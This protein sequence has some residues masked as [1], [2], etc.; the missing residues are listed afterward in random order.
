[1]K[2]LK[3]IHKSILINLLYVQTVHNNMYT[4]N[5]IYITIYCVIICCGIHASLQPADKETRVKVYNI[6]YYNTTVISHMSIQALFFRFYYYFSTP[7]ESMQCGK[8][9]LGK[10]RRIF[11]F[12]ACVLFYNNN[13]VRICTCPSNRNFDHCQLFVAKRFR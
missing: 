11:F 12:A 10:F 1:M 13:N 2:I 4:N 8:N 7:C 9:H 6:L 5:R 3:L